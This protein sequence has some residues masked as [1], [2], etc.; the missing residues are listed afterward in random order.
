MIKMRTF[1]AAAVAA[2]SLALGVAAT[3]ASAAPAP[4]GSAVV[5]AQD[6]AASPS[7]AS[8]LVSHAVPG[9]NGDCM[10]YF[11]DGA[12]AV[13]RLCGTVAYGW[14]WGDGRHEWVLVGSDQQV[15]HTFQTSANGSWSTWATPGT[16]SGVKG[17]V[18]GQFVN[19]IPT[20]AVLGSDDLPWCNTI[21]SSGVWTNWYSC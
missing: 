17:G 3:P 18:L 15:W 8:T 21:N 1:A 4:N 2:A 19:G 10:A 9:S 11:T 14:I 13:P 20:V 16:S 6:T 7:T 12:S 5:G